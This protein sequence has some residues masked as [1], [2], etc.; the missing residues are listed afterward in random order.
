MHVTSSVVV[1]LSNHHQEAMQSQVFYVHAHITPRL[2][3]RN[4]MILFRHF[5]LA[6][7]LYYTVIY[8]S[9]SSIRFA[10]NAHHSI[11]TV[12]IC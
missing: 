6:V 5:T 10:H 9:G 1:S 7:V 2:C 3:V 4:M 8:Y 11:S 12:C